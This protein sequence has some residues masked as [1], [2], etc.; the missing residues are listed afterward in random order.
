MRASSSWSRTAS[1]RQREAARCRYRTSGRRKKSQSCFRKS[2]P[3]KD[4]SKDQDQRDAQHKEQPRSGRRLRLLQRPAPSVDRPSAAAIA[5]PVPLPE[6][7]P[8]IAPS[9]DAR[10]HRS[11]INLR[12]R[13]TMKRPA[14]IPELPVAAAAK[15][16]AERGRARAVGQCCEANQAAAQESTVLP[17]LMRH[18][19]IRNTGRREA[20]EPAK[21]TAARQGNPSRQNPRCRRPRRRWR[22]SDVVSARNCH[23]AARRSM[24]GSICTA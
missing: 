3:L 9:G 21:A 23:A 8:N 2:I 10:R 4:P 11:A 24:Q 18:R 15:A 7:R 20:R 22:R 6:A 19:R 17:R 16:C 12:R 13:G 5:K 1:I 14:P